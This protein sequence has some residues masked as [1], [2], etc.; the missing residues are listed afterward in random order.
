MTYASRQSE[1]EVLGQQQQQSA[2]QPSNGTI[3]NG[4]MSDAQNT[5]SEKKSKMPLDIVVIILL[6]IIAGLLSFQ[7]MVIGKKVNAIHDIIVPPAADTPPPP[8]NS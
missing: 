8:P 6:V 3:Q 1:A 5:A 4:G 2:Y 7:L